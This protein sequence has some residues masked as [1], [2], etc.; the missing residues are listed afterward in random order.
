MRNSPHVPV[1]IMLLFVAA[2]ALLKGYGGSKLSA[3]PVDNSAPQTVIEVQGDGISHGS[4]TFFSETLTFYQL[5]AKFKLGKWCRDH[6][7]PAQGNLELAS[8]DKVDFRKKG[9]KPEIGL[10]IEKM[11]GLK[12]LILEIPLDPNKEKAVDLMAV[13]GIG[14]VTAGE[15]IKYRNENGGFRSVNQLQEILGK[16]VKVTKYFRVDSRNYNPENNGKGK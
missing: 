12:R 9:P 4:Y 16:R 2:S 8:G 1:L 7:S 10:K 11:A 3:A 14:P 6:I 15:I 13:P 5:C